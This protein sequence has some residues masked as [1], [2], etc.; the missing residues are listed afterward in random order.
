MQEFLKKFRLWADF[1]A[2][3]AIFP[4]KTGKHTVYNRGIFLYNKENVIVCTKLKFIA[5]FDNCSVYSF[6]P[7]EGMRL[8]RELCDKLKFEIYQ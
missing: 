4:E 1:V 5:L 6:P 8:R 2:I 7:G 3:K